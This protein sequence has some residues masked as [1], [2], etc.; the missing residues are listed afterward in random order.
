MQGFL[1]S[2]GL[3]AVE[4]EALLRA[5]R[6]LE[7]PAR[8]SRPERTLLLVDDDP[9]VTSVM[10]EVL[11]SAGYQIFTATCAEDGLELLAL[12]PVG[13][14]VCDQ[15]MPGMS[16]I[17]LLRRSKEIYPE[18]VRILLSGYADRETVLDAINQGAVYKVLAKPFNQEM[19][20]QTVRDAFRH[21]EL[22]T[23][24]EVRHECL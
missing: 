10:E 13:V 18:T 8:D 19:L 17:E 20:R 12:H 7:L 14:M 2:R 6:R 22:A 4:F 5:E 3:P 9:A 1:F 24:S 11:G 23:G 15:R 16:G 21:Y